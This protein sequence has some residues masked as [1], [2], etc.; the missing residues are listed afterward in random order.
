MF[1]KLSQNLQ[2]NTCARVSFLTVAGLR[3][4]VWGVK[5]LRGHSQNFIFF[6]KRVDNLFYSKSQFLDPIRTASQIRALLRSSHWRCS[7]NKAVLKNFVIFIEK[8][9]CWSLFLPKLQALRPATLL[10]KDSNTGVFLWI[11][12]KFKEH[13]IWRTSAN[14][15][16]LLLRVISISGE[17]HQS[18]KMNTLVYHLTHLLTGLRAPLNISKYYSF[19]HLKLFNALIIQKSPS[20]WWI[21]I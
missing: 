5:S 16:F 7:I 4:N 8:H 11:K 21:N 3:P 1:L 15:Y 13:L 2:E 10:E 9:L 6:Y 14:S 18:G 19:Q 20:H 17:V 12:G